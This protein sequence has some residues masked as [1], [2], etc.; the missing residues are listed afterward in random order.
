[1][2][3]ILVLALLSSCA[4]AQSQLSKI[5]TGELDRNFNILKQ[6]GDPAPYF[7][8]Y[9][10]TDRETDVIVASAGSVDGQNHNHSRLLDV[11]VR[12]GT[13]KFD[14]YRRVNGQ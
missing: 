5:L 8:G 11:T 3:I 7:M 10:V 13:P 9:S 6:K 4:P 1:M 2:R 14:N 12:V